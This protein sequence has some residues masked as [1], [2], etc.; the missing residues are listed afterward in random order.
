M[1]K[2]LHGV[3][4]LGIGTFKTII[5]N[6]RKDCMIRWPNLISPF[7][8]ITVD[9][10]G[11][12]RIGK[13]IKIRSGTKVRV[14]KKGILIIGDNLGISNNCVITAYEKIEIGDG[15]Q[16]GP[17]V[18]VYDHDHDFR[19]PGGLAANKFKT[20]PIKIGNN[21]WIG[22]NSIILRGSSIG[23]NSVIA[24]G[25]I[26]KGEV[27]DNSVVYQKRNTIINRYK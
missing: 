17:G 19:A 22:A 4:C 13:M 10:G 2:N 8:E 21:V 6:C 14:R 16:F 27:P 26:I 7:T 25:S 15:V 11:F 20:A 12:L 24:A 1:N 9:K 18:L 23:D 5:N 3:I